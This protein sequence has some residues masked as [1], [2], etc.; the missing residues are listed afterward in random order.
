[1]S[2]LHKS[3]RRAY[4]II[5]G[6]TLLCPLLFSMVLVSLAG[7]D[8]AT[9]PRYPTAQLSPLVTPAPTPTVGIQTV[10]T[11]TAEPTELPQ[12]H[13]TAVP[14]PA[15]P[16]DFA[17]YPA[18]VVGYLNDSQGDED[19]LRKMLEEWQALRDVAGLLRVDVDDDGKG[20]LLLIIVDAEGEFGI[21]L[22]GDLLI[23]D[24]EDHEYDLAYRATSDWAILDPSLLEVDDLND[25]G[26]T[27]LAFTS[28]SCGAHTCFT[29]VYILASGTGTYDDLTDGGIEM[30]YADIQ[31]SDWDADG[32][33]D[34][35][36][37]GGMI[38][39]VGAGPQRSRTEVYRWDGAAYTIAEKTYDPSNY[40]YFK[41]LDANEALLDGSYQRAAALYEEAIRNPDLDVW[42]EESERE[43]L[44]AFARYRL[45]LTYLLAG[46]TA[47]ADLV[48]DELLRE[49]PE[50]IYAQVVTVLWDAYL[51]GADL[52]TAC[53]AVTSFAAAHPETSGMLADYGYANPTFTSEEVCPASLF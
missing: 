37:H 45:C 6:K 23:I 8:L 27:E 7:C 2:T 14:F 17:D 29:T 28:T 50:D 26:H 15:R 49:Q 21:N 48:R 24:M 53:E 52:R 46:Q 34:L 39:S 19:G 36:M 16:Q 38:G 47:D 32:M 20:E 30:S 31:L 11:P 12:A 9:L 42:M 18:A 13:P 33:L 41:V 10:L 43:E 25:D 40:L 51:A 22:A 4:Q 3:T 5:R 35:V 1:M 44:T